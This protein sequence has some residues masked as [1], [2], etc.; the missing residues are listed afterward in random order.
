[1]MKLLTFPNPILLKTCNPVTEFDEDLNK[2]LQEMWSIMQA[3][4]GMG[5]AANQVGLSKTMFVMETLPEKEKLFVVNPVIITKSNVP[6]N[7]REGCLSAPGEFVIRTD[8]ASWVQISFKDE[9]GQ[10]HT[11]AFHGI[12]SVCVLHEMEHLEGQAFFSSSHVPKSLR[13][14]LLKKWGLK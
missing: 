14:G 9:K 11:R 6:A 4:G 10:S 8:R 3:N 12:N 5:L 13:M 7:M 2:T 1:M